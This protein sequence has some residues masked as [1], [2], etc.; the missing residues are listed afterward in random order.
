M[1]GRTNIGKFSIPGNS[2]QPK[3]ARTGSAFTLRQY[4]PARPSAGRNTELKTIKLS[5]SQQ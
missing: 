3:N 5:Y 1:V 4:F 2:G